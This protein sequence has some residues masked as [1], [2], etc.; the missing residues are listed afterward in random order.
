[1]TKTNWVG[2][3]IGGRFSIPLC[4][5]DQNLPGLI[6]EIVPVTAE[7]QSL[8]GSA[9]CNEWSQCHVSCANSVERGA[10]LSVVKATIALVSHDGSARPGRR[11]QVSDAFS[12]PPQEI[13]PQFFKCVVF[14][15]LEKRREK[16][17]CFYL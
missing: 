4:M 5:Q 11:W 14:L 9:C 15:L 7:R 13:H 17:V 2:C 3:K 8:G 12:F 6:W 1:M 10:F 16:R